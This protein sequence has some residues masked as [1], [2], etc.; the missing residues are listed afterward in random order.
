MQVIN[1]FGY[2]LK[3]LTCS[4]AVIALITGA[5]RLQSVLRNVGWRAESGMRFLLRAHKLRAGCPARPLAGSLVSAPQPG[6]G[7]VAASSLRHL[8]RGRPL[9]WGLGGAG[10][11]GAAH[12]RRWHEGVLS[13][14]GGAWFWPSAQGVVSYVSH[15]QRSPVAGLAVAARVFHT[16]GC[17]WLGQGSVL[18]MQ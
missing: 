3:S 16:Q 14:R 5:A 13:L 6:T 18:H 12:A 4:S 1:G 9:R 8:L 2:F 15:A 17:P 10:A 7:M 11:L